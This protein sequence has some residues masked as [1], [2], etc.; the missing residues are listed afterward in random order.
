[1]RVVIEWE[2]YTEFLYPE[3]ETEEP[4]AKQYAL[5]KLDAYERGGEHLKKSAVWLIERLDYLGSIGW[6]LV[7]MQPH[8]IGDNQDVLI[9][10][11]NGNNWSN[12]YLLVFKRHKP[13]RERPAGR[14]TMVERD[15]G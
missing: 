2:Y 4:E 1:V 8:V 12:G 3:D 6:E 15:R 5:R 10:S 14:P 13:T 11:A 7:A 9:A